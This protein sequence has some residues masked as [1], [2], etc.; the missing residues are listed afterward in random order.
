MQGGL[1]TEATLIYKYYTYP[2]F[3]K[4]I[5]PYCFQSFLWDRELVPKVFK[6][7]FGTNSKHLLRPSLR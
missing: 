6:V 7:D 5:G 1:I 3:G 4:N 2:E